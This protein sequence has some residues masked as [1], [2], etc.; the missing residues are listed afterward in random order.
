MKTAAD[1]AICLLKLAHTSA[2]AA[3]ADE[4]RRMA[5]VK[6]ALAVL[7]ADDFA[8]V[9]PAIARDV[10]AGVYEALGTSDP[11]ERIKAEHNA[12]AVEL[13]RAWA[14]GYLDAAADGEE[15]LARAVRVAL[16]GNGMDPASLPDR[17]DPSGFEEWARAPWAVY[18]W[19]DFKSDLGKAGDVLYLCDNAGEIAFDLYL[20]RELLARGKK[21][22][23]SVKG[24]PALNDATL[25]DAETVGISRAAGPA[26]P[27]EL[28]T[29]G[30][31]TMGV[32]PETASPQWLER[33][34]RASI[35][36]AKGQANL[37]CLH[38]VG[39]TVYFISLIKCS[40][41]ARYYG[42]KK[43]AAM[44]YKGGKEN[45]VD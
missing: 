18:D 11:F 22:T 28:I 33:F 35:I 27:A 41:V 24:G 13:A 2:S 40:H 43:G 38:D 9:P 3:G 37:E 19:E 23:V 30:L 42:K 31:A 39:R 17:A 25:A 45:G 16:A 6:A 1:C 44:L 34:Q 20:I 12:K 5:A 36:I 8:R 29:T 26:G 21:V 7:A 14:P 32:D 4:T 10:L 15:R